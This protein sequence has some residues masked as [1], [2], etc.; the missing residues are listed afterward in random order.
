[1]HNYP[2]CKHCLN[3]S[4][5]VTTFHSAWFEFGVHTDQPHNVLSLA[6]QDP[7]MLTNAYRPDI[8]L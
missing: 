5:R 7:G 8:M 2:V 4:A 3:V 6:C 1:M